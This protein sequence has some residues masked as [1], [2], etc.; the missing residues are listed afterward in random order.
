MSS[1]VFRFASRGWEDVVIEVTLDKFVR[2]RAQRLLKSSSGR[3]ERLIESESRGRR[4]SRHEGDRVLVATVLV[5]EKGFD[6]P[7]LSSPPSRRRYGTCIKIC[8]QSGQISRLTPCFIF[9]FGT[10]DS[11]GRWF[12]VSVPLKNRK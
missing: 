9:A 5:K 2:C 4:G 11:P 1:R 10:A 12:C 8:A 6:F 3:G 7:G